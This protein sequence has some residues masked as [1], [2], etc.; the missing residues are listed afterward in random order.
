MRTRTY[1]SP[2]LL[3]FVFAAFVLAEPPWMELFDGGTLSGWEQKGGQATF[4]V[5]DGQIIGQTVL[6]TPDSSLCTRQFYSDFILELEFNV[7]QE[8]NSGVYIRSN[9]FPEYRDGC[10]HGYQI[11]IDPSDRAWTGGIYDSSCRGWLYTLEDNRA[12][13][14]AFKA[15]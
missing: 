1:I 2:L 6:N 11:E 7:E 4:A 5:R 9:S 3:L 15:G 8:L 12:A 10:V 13:Q 14:R